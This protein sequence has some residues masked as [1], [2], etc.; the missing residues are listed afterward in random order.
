MDA[1]LVNEPPSERSWT[2]TDWERLQRL[3]AGFLQ[4]GRAADWRDERDL[5]LYDAVFGERILWKWQAVLRLL[6]GSGWKPRSSA[7]LDWGCGTGEPSR[8]L[9][10][11]AG[12]T[13][14]WLHDLSPLAR[15][16]AVAKHRADGHTIRPGLP[17]AGEA[18]FLFVLSHVLG[19]LQEAGQ[20]EILR[21][22]CGAG[23]ILWLEPGDRTT[24]RALGAMRERLRAEGFRVV[25][26]CPHQHGCPVLQ[27]GQEREWCHFFARPP[28]WIFQSSAW[29]EAAN[30]LEIDLRSL[31]YSFL[32]LTRD[33]PS[34]PLAEPWR[35]G[36]RLLGRA[37]VRKGEVSMQTCS[38]EGLGR[39]RWQKREATA[40]YRELKH[41]PEACSGELVAPEERTKRPG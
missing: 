32:V 5:E 13:Q 38:A 35:G 41:H 28:G 34:D 37:E 20:Q 17:G 30:K 24:S 9:A 3:R 29:R 18:P 22:A 2:R 8:L 23:E 40:L 27:A 11:W 25:A 7:L 1:E 19:E 16:R 36:R 4:G 21:L 15:A 14:V 31:P 26:P 39:Q 6:E 12:V 10:R 33:A